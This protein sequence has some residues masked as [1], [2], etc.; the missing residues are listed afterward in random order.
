MLQHIATKTACSSC[1]IRDLCMPVGLS[2][3]EMTL[4][5]KMVS[6]RLKVARGEVLFSAGGA[7]KSLFTIRS[8]F[9]KTTMSTA[10][11]REQVSGFY[12]AGELL[13]LDGIAQEQHSCTARALEDSDVCV[14]HVQLINALA[15]DVHALQ[16]HVQKI[17]S[18]EIVHDHDHLFL[19]GSMK[20]DGRVATFLLNLLTR[21]HARGQAQ[22]E[23][24]LRMTREDIGSYLGLTIETVSRTLSKLAK[25]G[26]IVVNQRNI[27][28]LQPQ[29][30]HYLA[31]H[32]DT[33]ACKQPI[34]PSH[35]MHTNLI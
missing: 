17:M 1:R 31:E 9:F 13:G 28:V 21:L 35:A 18:R 8:G 15:H 29:I 26:V 11:G 14:L 2:A 33:S 3:K 22:D 25:S 24:S 32:G 20:A 5:D 27:R 7:F 4:I 10:D 12:M 6:T 34:L 23:L 16:H 19:L 30:L